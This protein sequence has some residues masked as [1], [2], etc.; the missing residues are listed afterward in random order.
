ETLFQLIHLYFKAP[1]RDE[2][3]FRRYREGFRLSSAERA[4]DPDATFDDSV[5]VAS[6]LLPTWFRPSM[7]TD[8]DAL[9]LDGAMS[10]WQARTANASSFTTVIVGDITIERA[11]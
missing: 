4:I 2:R 10:Y 6:G 11:K 7:L 8:G 5:S 1:R 3:A 9:T